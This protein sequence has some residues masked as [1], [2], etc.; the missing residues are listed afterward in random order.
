MTLDFNFNLITLF[1]F[2]F[3]DSNSIFF[4]LFFLCTFFIFYL[5]YSKNNSFDIFD[6]DRDVFDSKKGTFSEWP[7]GGN[8]NDDDDDEKKKKREKEEFEPMDIMDDLYLT[9]FLIAA[10]AVVFMLCQPAPITIAEIMDKA[11]REYFT[12]L[13]KN[14]ENGTAGFWVMDEEC[15]RSFHTYDEFHKDALHDIKQ[16]FGQYLDDPKNPPKS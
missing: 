8:N 16:R 9:M 3:N 15:N 10:C 6:S 2:F 1:D 14:L 11:S 12:E 13:V 5:F 4:I 7:G